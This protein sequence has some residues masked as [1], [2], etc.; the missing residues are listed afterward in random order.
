MRTSSPRKFFSIPT[1]FDRG[2]EMI[3]LDDL[4]QTLTFR[5]ALG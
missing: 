3:T 4:Q 1:L 2:I 5:L